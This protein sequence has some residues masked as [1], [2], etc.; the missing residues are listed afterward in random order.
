MCNKTD[1][2]RRTKESNLILILQEK[3]QI[4]SIDKETYG[5]LVFNQ[6][7]VQYYIISFKPMEEKVELP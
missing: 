6:I 3:E 5:I 4:C 1:L 2:Y 7:L